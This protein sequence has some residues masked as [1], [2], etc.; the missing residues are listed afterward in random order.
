MMK[1]LFWR[2][3]KKPSLPLVTVITATYNAAETIER[4][5]ASVVQQIYKNIEFILVD[6]LSQDRTPEIIKAA[7]RNDRRIRY[8]SE[9]DYGPYDAMN[10]GISM[11][12]GDWV[13]FLGADDVLVHDHILQELYDE[14]LFSQEK[15]FYG[16]VIIEGETSWAKDQ[17]VYAGEFDLATFLKR[18]I[19]HQSIFYPSRIIRQAGFF[20]QDYVV[21]A[22]WDYNMRCYALEPFLFVDKVI[23]RFHAGGISSSGND[24]A[25]SQEFPGNIIRYFSLDPDDPALVEKDAVFRQVVLTYRKLKERNT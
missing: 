2:K 25:F 13:Y 14:G 5:I 4:T 19:C 15:V 7:A 18:N 20:N 10:K 16:N 8:I 24:P 12:K 3:R 21:C 1:L 22:D 9:K 11:S 6:G 23:A 17:E